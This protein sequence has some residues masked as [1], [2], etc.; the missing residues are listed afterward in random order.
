[1]RLYTATAR[2]GS[3]SK[4]ILSS[5]SSKDLSN[6]PLSVEKGFADASPAEVLYICFTSKAS[7]FG[8]ASSTRGLLGCWARAV[9]GV[10]GVPL[11]EP[12]AG[13]LLL[14]GRFHLRLGGGGGG[15]VEDVW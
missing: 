9:S 5:P 6:L 8:T 11:A 10:V 4:P 15:M 13:P 3:Y 1:V 7:G 2:E 12:L 14:R